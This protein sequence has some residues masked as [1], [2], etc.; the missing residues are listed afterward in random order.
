MPANPHIQGDERIRTA[1][2]VKPPIS[3]VKDAGQQDSRVAPVTPAA[4][5]NGG[6]S[7][8]PLRGNGMAGSATREAV[9]ASGLLQ[10]RGRGWGRPATSPRG[11]PSFVQAIVLAAV[12][13]YLSPW[14]LLG[15]VPVSVW[16]YG[17]GTR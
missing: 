15:A 16:A 8:T 17:R 4:G 9:L 1:V 11:C 7:S 10:G 6:M 2:T 14:L 12:L 3:S 13:L 5:V